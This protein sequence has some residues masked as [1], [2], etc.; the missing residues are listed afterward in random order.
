MDWAGLMQLGLRGLRLSPAEFWALTPMELQIISGLD[1]APTAMGRDR[2]NELS[3]AFP[4][5][6]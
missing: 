6:K 5:N 3:N 1:E 4:D 2:L